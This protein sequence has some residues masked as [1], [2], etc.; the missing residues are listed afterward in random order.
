MFPP[1]QIVTTPQVAFISSKKKLFV[2]PSHLPKFWGKKPK[3]TTKVTKNNGKILSLQFTRHF[4][5]TPCRN[6]RKLTFSK[7]SEGTDSWFTII[8]HEFFK[9]TFVKL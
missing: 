7:I 4:A 9:I 5:S 3:A 8:V 1:P 6:T 2:G